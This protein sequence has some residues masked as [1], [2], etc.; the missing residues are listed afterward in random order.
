MTSVTS[1]DPG[2]GWLRDKSFD[3]LFIVG[4]S[5]LA[6][7]S[8]LV[9]LYAPGLFPYVLFLDLWFLGYHHV[10]STYT[11]LCF[12]RES[13]REHWFLM[14]GLLPLVVLAVFL[15]GRW[16]GFW[17]IASIYLYW[18]WFHYTRQ[19]W[20]IQQAYR[21]KAKGQVREPDWLIKA[22]FYLLPLTG[23][24][25]RSWQA[26]P[27]FLGM[28]LRVVPVPLFLVVLV[29]AAALVSVL[30]FSWLRLQAFRRGEGPL[31]HTWYMVSHCMIF[32][33]GYLLIEDITVGWLVINIWHN[34]QY[35]LFVWHFNTNKFRDGVSVK[36]H[37]LSYLSQPKNWWLYFGLCLAI[38]TALYGSL[39]YASSFVATV[40]VPTGIVVFQSLNFHHYI[41]D[42]RIW[43]L[44][45]PRLQETLDIAKTTT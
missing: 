1:V 9:V 11:R 5:I 26:P 12:D 15:V 44:R 41:V 34:A 28:E 2:Q 21:A 36:A 33:A 38:T 31:A 3:T 13:L 25:Y 45:K 6:V 35:M 14:F 17:A 8:G 32:S 23:I 16:L 29:G 4:I 27:T 39:K 42:S 37:L 19:S 43:K 18:Q 20:G 24:L 22:M 10:V 7:Y 30:W 40:A